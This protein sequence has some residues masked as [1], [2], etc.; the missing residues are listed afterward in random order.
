MS[1]KSEISIVSP[2]PWHAVIEAGKDR[3]YLRRALI[4]QRR[5]SDT[6]AYFG[7][8]DQV[9]AL[10]MLLSWRKRRIEFALSL[11]RAALPYI[12]QLIRIA[13]LTLSQMRDAGLLIFCRVNPLNKAGQR[14]ARLVGFRP[15][16]L[17]DTSIWIFDGETN[18]LDFRR[19]K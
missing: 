14:M 3:P 11:N 12:R 16:R 19:Q 18:G 8:G 1:S 15:A 7:P 5:M 13:H 4:R 6:I 10:A 2:A 9:L 17:K